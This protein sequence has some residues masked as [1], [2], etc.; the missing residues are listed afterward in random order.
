M[1]FRFN[2]MGPRWHKLYKGTP[3]EQALEDAVARLGVPYRSQFPGFLYGF[4][5]FPDFFLPTLQ[6]VIEVD[7]TS[8]SRAAKILKDAER[9]EALESKGWQVVRCSNREALDDPDGAVRRCLIEAGLWPLPEN[10]PKL[11]DCMP[12]LGKVPKKEQREAKTAQR[13]HRRGLA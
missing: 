1:S 9:T 11:A 10:L 8:H 7:D 13:R 3:A 12:K 6:L 5:Y 4:R 2:P